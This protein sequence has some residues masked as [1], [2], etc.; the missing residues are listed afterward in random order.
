MLIKKKYV[1]VKITKSKL[2]KRSKELSFLLDMSN[3]LSTASDLQTLLDGALSRVLKYFDL[4][5]GRIYL[6]DREKSCFYLTAHQGVEPYGLETLGFDEG[7]SGKAARTK[8][9]I[10]Q[11][12]SELKNKRR[13]DLLQSKGLKIIVCVPLISMHNV[14]GV[15]N[16]ASKRIIQLD[17]EKIDLSIAIGNQIAI[18]ANNAK[19]H[20]ELQNKIKLLN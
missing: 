6:W 19:I 13:A 4:D 20:N 8:S 17:Q 18:A 3:F 15:M 16:L 14:E 2:Q 11:H 9:F 12:V 5:A 1:S 10:A 7:F